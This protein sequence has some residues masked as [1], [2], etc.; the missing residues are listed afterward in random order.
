MCWGQP[1]PDWSLSTTLS[2]PCLGALQA[3]TWSMLENA[4]LT[5][6]EY[7][8]LHN[9]VVTGAPEQSKDWDTLLLPFQQHRH[10]LT[11]TGPVVLISE[12]PVVPKSLRSRVL[13]HFHAGHPGLSTMCIR[14]SN[15]LYWPN[16]KEDL[17]RSKLSCTT[18]MAKAP[19]NQAMPLA[20]L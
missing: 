15:S 6:P 20:S 10:L 7:Q 12:R 13:D 14:L 3:V 11:V 2:N 19:S 8:L 18:C 17:I 1:R 5:Y 9:L 16:Y 4:F